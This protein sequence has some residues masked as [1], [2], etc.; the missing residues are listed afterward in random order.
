M[1]Q[2]RKPSFQR[3]PVVVA[4]HA[5]ASQA[6]EERIA[7]EARRKLIQ[8]RILA[9]HDKFAKIRQAEMRAGLP[10]TGNLSTLDANNLR[11]LTS[12]IIA[13]KP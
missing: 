4:V 8:G 1:A 12:M 2:Q 13:P 3:S 9:L 10:H 11:A 5:Y 7:R 6:R